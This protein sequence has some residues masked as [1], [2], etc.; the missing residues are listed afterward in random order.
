[1]L[2]IKILLVDDEETLL[3]VSKIYLKKMNERY[4]IITTDSAIKALEIIK[5]EEFDVIIS[6]YRMP[7]MNGLE[8]LSALR[9]DGNE[10]PFIIFTGKGREEVA[11]QALNLGADF[12]LQK[13]GETTSQFHE[14]ENLIDNLFEKK[15]TDLARKHLLDQQIS[16]NELALT[17]GETRDLNKIYKTIFHHIYS[18]MDADTFVVSFY[19]KAKETISPGY[20]LIEGNVLDITVF[21]P[22]SLSHRESEIQN[23]VITTEEYVY[24]PDLRRTLGK[25]TENEKKKHYEGDYTKSAVYVPMKIGGEI[26]G[27]IE[28]QSYDYNA[29]SQQDI[30]LLSALA[31]VAAIAIQNARLFNLLQQTNIELLAEKNRTQMYLDVVDVIVVVFDLNANVQMINKR[32]CEILGYTEEEIINKDWVENF[33]PK[34]LRKG[35]RERLSKIVK[36]NNIQTVTTVYVENP[37]LTKSGKERNIS[38]KTN[39]LRDNRNQIIGFLSSG[40][41]IIDQNVA[42]EDTIESSERKYRSTLDSL[43]DPLHVVDENLNFVLTNKALIDWLTSLKIESNLMGKSV[44]E[45]FPF[46]PDEVRDE[47]DHVFKTGEILVTYGSDELEDRT[48]HTKTRKIP[49]F[50][51]G[52][53]VRI[54]TIIS[55]ISENVQIE[56]N[57]REVAEKYSI[58]FHKSNDIVI[59][60]NLDSKILDV[61]QRTLEILGYFK[62]E[63][64]KMNLFEF[65]TPTNIEQ[66]RKALIQIQETKSINSEVIIRKRNGEEIFG[67]L[68]ASVIELS[69]SKIV[70]GIIRDITTRKLME[71]VQSKRIKDLLFLSNSAMHF[72]EQTF[73]KN[74]YQ[75]IAEQIK[76]LA[77]N[78]YIITA[79]YNEINE[80]FNIKSLLGISKQFQTITKILGRDPY[81]VTA[82]L[83][84]KYLEREIFGKIIKIEDDLHD[85]SLGGIT[86]RES[87]LIFR[88]LK[89]G[90]VYSA[91][92]S[93]DKHIAGAVLILMKKGY[94]LKNKD[95]IEAFVNQSSVA[96]LRNEAQ[97]ELQKSEERFRN[98]I[99]STPLGIHMYNLDAENN[100]IFQGAN[101]SANEILR[102]D[103]DTL[104]GKKIEDAFPT[105]VESGL[106]KIYKKIAEEGGV[107]ETEQIYYQDKNVSSAFEVRVFHSKPGSVVVIFQDITEK[108]V[109]KEE[110]E[111]NIL[112]L[113]FLSQTAMD[114]IGFSSDFDIYKYIGERMSELIDDSYIIVTSFDEDNYSFKTQSLT[115]LEG[116]TKNLVAI[117]GKNPMELE[118]PIREE[119]LKRLIANQFIE[120]DKP[121]SEITQGAIQKKVTATMIKLLNIGKAYTI[122]F[123]SK[124]KLVGAVI[125]LLKK[126][127]KISRIPMLVAFAN[128]A[129]V[130]LVRKQ[131]E[132][133]LQNSEKRFRTLIETMNDG[134]GIDNKDGVNT[135]VN[136]KLCNMLGYHENEVLGRKVTDF[137]DEENKK[138]YLEHSKNRAEGT[139]ESYEISWVRK[140]GT[141]K[142]TI[143]SPQ[144]IFDSEGQYDGSF[145]VITD[146]TERILSE[147]KLMQ[148][149]M[150]LQKQRDELESFAS[151]IAH[152]LRGKMQVIS[153]YNSMLDSEYSQKISESIDEMSSFI[154]DLLLLAKKGELLGEVSKVNLND[155]LTKMSEKIT[156]LNPE[157]K[158][159]VNKLPKVLG[160]SI[161]LQ[162]VFENLLMNIVKH[163]EATESVID[164]EETKKHFIISVKDNGKG[165]SKKKL[166]EI[167][168]S[169]TTKRYSS[170][171]LLIV[172]TVMRAHEG[173]IKIE[174]EEGKGTIIKLLFRKKPFKK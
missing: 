127:K 140:D 74:I 47:Y 9:E 146:I 160:D 55:D 111:R 147:E 136:A 167:N 57:L 139:I 69:G 156:S 50:D 121:M 151:T 84:P 169:W 95:L 66:T 46:L 8:F 24:L 99:N 52:K 87:S 27:V 91:T 7:K 58:L 49:I 77:G 29:Y 30:E 123:K 73:T 64:L 26:I 102:I 101:P 93:K 6:D 28:V 126:N 152:D 165:I 88:L 83:N 41:D 33:L 68:S 90:K 54:I 75:Y 114:L 10:I 171:G 153:L 11:I 71:D 174:S 34:R 44:F 13:G 14:L 78:A 25:E 125:I 22:M 113:T 23:K 173:D 98:I 119:S 115:G 89:I 1:M 59:L 61:N 80:D 17:L 67:E 37:I 159:E 51:N 42:I 2:E 65:A 100:L 130:A 143:I 21:P 144:P 163:A 20:A 108:K 110:E 118:I 32:G 43:A 53:V 128:Q 161:K 168:E 133:E 149:Q 103:H 154:E 76:D 116:F 129:S 131:A 142:P 92:F 94:N 15:Q 135:Y 96:I 157:L 86:K 148:S 4:S 35:L 3:E 164:S 38:W 141:K 155:M 105:S 60:F 97:S 19:N 16:I 134:L 172:V 82:K 122:P 117:L 109:A 48:I 31:N 106:A 162:Q 137:L 56:N 18:I 107:W 12:Y 81:K 5:K 62:D 158:I 166:K 79:S 104:R 120:I 70:Q 39:I 63:I 138:L 150:E 170:F 36:N 112:N 85:L 45:A 40:L 124:G 145:A 72:V 132:D